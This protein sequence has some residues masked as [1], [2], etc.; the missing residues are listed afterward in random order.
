MPDNP[1]VAYAMTP[2]QEMGNAFSMVLPTAI[3]AF[4]AWTSPNRLV[5]VL[6]VG[7]SMHLPISFTYHMC[8]AFNRYTD[9]LDND[10]RRL[11]Q[12]MQHVVGTIFSFALSGSVN[13][14]LLN[15]LLNLRGLF[16]LW[17]KETS[18]DGKRWVPVLFCV[19]M[20][21]APMLWRGDFRN[22][23][24]AVAS[25]AVGG[26]SFVPELNKRIFLGWGHT[27]FHVVLMVYAQALANS[28]KDI[29]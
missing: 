10:M 2:A 5:V 17:S 28:A 16:L 7:S 15:L 24:V 22:Y 25:M 21:T 29:Q 6:L 11:D 20:Y 23:I 26:V 4:N 27:I 12:S 9:R 1:S 18:N 3:L 13:Y 19:L 14:M 8:A